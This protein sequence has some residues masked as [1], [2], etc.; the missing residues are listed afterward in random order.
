[1]TKVEFNANAALIKLLLLDQFS[2]NMNPEM[3][4]SDLLVS[5]ELMSHFYWYMSSR[6][7]PEASTPP[8]SKEVKFKKCCGRCT[9]W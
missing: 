9:S 8:S 4:I 3:E 1:M 7:A 6:S 2:L 5:N